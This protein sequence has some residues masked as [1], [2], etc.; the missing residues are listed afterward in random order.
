MNAFC[1]YLSVTMEAMK[2]RPLLMLVLSYFEM[3]FLLD[4]FFMNFIIITIIFIIAII[5]LQGMK[6]K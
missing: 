2:D 4:V 6:V 1:L 5:M 3:V